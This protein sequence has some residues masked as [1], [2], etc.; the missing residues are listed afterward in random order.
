M[1]VGKGSTAGRGLKHASTYGGAYALAAGDAQQEEG[2][3]EATSP[4]NRSPAP[5]PHPSQQQQQQQQQ[6]A[7]ELSCGRIPHVT[8]PP[9]PGPRASAPPHYVDTQRLAARQQAARNLRIG[10]G[11]ALSPLMERTVRRAAEVEVESHGRKAQP[12][13]AGTPHKLAPGSTLPDSRGA[14][15]LRKAQALVPPRQPAEGGRPAK[16]PR[17]QADRALSGMHSA[18]TEPARD[19]AEASRKSALRSATLAEMSRAQFDSSCP[20]PAASHPCMQALL[21]EKDERIA[22]LER[23]QREAAARVAHLEQICHRQRRLLQHPGPEL[24]EDL[25]AQHGQGTQVAAES[26]GSRVVSLQAE[27]PACQEPAVGSGEAPGQG[28]VA[29]ALQRKQGDSRADR[30]PLSRMALELVAQLERERGWGTPQPPLEQG[31]Q[32]Q[33]QQEQQEQQ[34]QAERQQQQR[35]AAQEEQTEQREEQGLQAEPQ[36]ELPL[37]QPA[38]DEAAWRQAEAALLERVAAAEEAARAAKEQADKRVARCRQRLDTILKMDTYTELNKMQNVKNRHRRAAREL[39]E[40]VDELKATMVNLRR[41]VQLRS[42]ELDDALAQLRLMELDG[43][44]AQ[45]EERIYDLE[46]QLQVAVARREMVDARARNFANQLER[47]KKR[48]SAERAEAERQRQLLAAA[49]EALLACQAKLM[50]AQLVKR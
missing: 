29:P 32:Q 34:G 48:T 16:R 28:D 42:W 37:P 13:K 5:S 45:A 31:E 50:R 21:R 11:P 47:Q 39:Q 18:P 19:T 44:G 24:E 38:A 14:A 9:P 4:A 43:P 26:G 35:Q 22:Q 23:L 10:A 15:M 40:R 1:C 41:R 12:P 46:R 33:E 17:A 7:G 36:E 20:H 6:Q 3:G 2:M 25:P 27:P 30:D 49:D 8:V